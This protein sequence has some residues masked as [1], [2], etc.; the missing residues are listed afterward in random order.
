MSEELKNKFAFA[1]FGMVTSHERGVSGRSLQVESARL[2]I[3]DA[4]LKREDIGGW[5]PL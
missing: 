5:A 1:G 4:G 3:A 2:A